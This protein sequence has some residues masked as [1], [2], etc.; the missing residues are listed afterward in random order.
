[1]SLSIG[2]ENSSSIPRRSTGAMTETTRESE[3]DPWDFLSRVIETSPGFDD[4]RGPEPS[5]R[6]L[7]EQHRMVHSTWRLWRGFSN[8]VVWP[9][10]A[11]THPGRFR[12]VWW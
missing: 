5:L 9:V 4:H 7:T 1:V 2:S 6:G 11:P 3:Q 8:Q 12:Y 10:E